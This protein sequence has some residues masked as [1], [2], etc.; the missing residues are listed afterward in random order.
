MKAIRICVLLVILF[1][2]SPSDFALGDNYLWWDENGN[3]H[4]T[5]TPPPEN[6]RTKDGKNFWYSD[7]DSGKFQVSKEELD[8]T[9]FNMDQKIFEGIENELESE[10]GLEVTKH[11]YENLSPEQKNGFWQSVKDFFTK[12][13]KHAAKKKKDCE[14]KWYAEKHGICPLEKPQINVVSSS[15]KAVVI[16]HRKGV[17]SSCKGTRN[18]DV[19]KFVNKGNGYWETDGGVSECPFYEGFKID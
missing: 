16:D 3:A 11:D 6:A 19:Y 14:Y 12:T 18:G 2:I 8:E 5:Q 17:W 10:E 7:D 4:A 9:Y 15:F 13:E 1:C